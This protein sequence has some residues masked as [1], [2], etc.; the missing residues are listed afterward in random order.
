MCAARLRNREH[1]CMVSNLA[2]IEEDSNDICPIISIL[3]FTCLLIIIVNT[4]SASAMTIDF[5]QELT[6]SLA[7]IKHLAFGHA[8]RKN[9]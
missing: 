5:A 9:R 3:V 6:L 8:S 4:K 1:K 2:L 7:Y